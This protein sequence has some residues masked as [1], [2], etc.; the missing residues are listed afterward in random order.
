MTSKVLLR[1]NRG[2]VIVYAALALVV[3]LGAAGLSIDMGNLYLQRDKAQ[4][5]ADAAA[6]AGAIQ[7]MNNQ[8]DVAASTAA[9]NVAASNGYDNTVTGTVVTCTPR[10][11]GNSSLYKVYV[12]KPAPVFFMAI[13]GWHFKTVGASATAKFIS[14]VQIDINGGGTYGV[15]G[16]INLSLFG[17]Y[18]IRAN[19][20]RYSTMYIDDKSPR[21][22]NPFYDSGGY[23]FNLTI[24]ADYESVNGTSKVDLQIFDPD[25]HNAGNAQNAQL[26]VSIDE[27]RNYAG[28]NTSDTRYLTTTQYNI[29]DT[30]GNTDPNDDTLIAQASYGNDSSTDMT[31]VTP[32]GF[33]FDLSDLSGS[34]ARNVRV[35]VKSTG[36]SSENGFSLRAGAPLYDVRERVANGKTQYKKV[37]NG[38]EKGSWLTKNPFNSNNGTSIT[39]DGRIP[40]NFNA[41]GQAVIALGYVAA[42]ASEVVISNFDT[43]VKAKSGVANTVTYSDGTNSWTGEMSGQD[44]WKQQTIDLPANYAGGNWTA[45]Y[46]AGLGDTSVW[47]MSS[48]GISLSAG[49]VYLVK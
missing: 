12:Q 20:D 44:E 32:D 37:V 35:N 8:G 21:T 48:S 18:C 9:T 45:T 39:A 14:P 15:I 19:G 49:K 40:M 16:P 38:V 17:P 25:C 43:D 27:M 29:Y 42:N 31:W 13:F 41:D 30:H 7:L 6:L 26:G 3:L 2:S 36:G 24:P 23:N 5:A 34:G 10:P 4:R 33:Q 11:N 22:P 28:Q 1:R 47:D 46:S